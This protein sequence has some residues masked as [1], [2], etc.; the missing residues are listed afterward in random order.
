MSTKYIYVMGSESGAGKSTVCLGILAHLLVS[1]YDPNRLAYIKPV[2]QCSELQRVTLFCEQTKIPYIDLGRLVFSK[3]FSK[4]FIDGLTK[5]TK[6]LMTDVLSSILELGNH[7]DVVIIDGVGDPSVGSV[8]GVSNVDVALS[9]P[10][11]V[12]FVGKPGIGSALDNTVLCVTFM[13]HKG[14]ANIGV[15]YN[16]IAPSALPEIKK[17]ITKRLPELLPKIKLLGFISNEQL[18][19]SQFKET[20]IKDIAHWFGSYLNLH[21]L[22][23]DWLELDLNYMPRQVR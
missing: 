22:L 21:F 7:K 5:P 4:D 2:T 14:L 1:G 11:H 19:E 13:Q 18:A 10:C 17:Y 20:V 8:V 16:K 6:S 9:L 3:G 12:I 15:I 23:H